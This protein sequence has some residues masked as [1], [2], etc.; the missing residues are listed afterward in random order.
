[1][2]ALDPLRLPLRG[3]QV[4]EASAG[5]GKTWTLAALYLR[6]VI[7]HGRP[8][9]TG[10]SPRQILVMTFTEAATAELRE[11]IRQRLHDAAVWFE[12]KLA[13]KPVDT[14]SFMDK[15]SADIPAQEWPQCVRR[16]LLAA[17]AMDEAA[18][19]T[20]HGWS[21]RMLSSF[22]LFS[23]DVFEQTHLDNPNEL[24]QQ[25]VRDHWRRWFYPLPQNL[26]QTLLTQLGDNPDTLLAELR[27]QWKTWDLLPPAAGN[28]A[29]ETPAT[30]PPLD[31]LTVFNDWQTKYQALEAEARQSWQADL[32]DRLREAR[33]AGLIKAAGIS[34]P[35][36]YKWVDELQDWAV[37]GKEIRPVTLKRFA[38]DKL[39]K[40]G[41]AAA[42]DFALFKQ[43]PRMVEFSEHPPA[44]KTLLIAHAAHAVRAAY[45]QA[46]LNQSV[47]DF[48]DLLQRL[49]Q[50]LH[51]DQGELAAAIRQQY[52]VAMVDEFQ[53][54]DP[55]QYESLDRIYQ[56]D[57]VDDSNVLVMIGDPKQAIYSF[58]GADLSTYLRAREYALAL[59]P[60]ACHT[61]DT[62]YR[63][64][65]A[66]VT[67]V[68]RVFGGID[69][70]FTSD[71]HSI[72]FTPVKSASDAL[73]LS[74]AS[75]QVQAPLT[76]WHLP[77]PPGITEKKYWPARDHVQTMAAGFASQM[78]VLLKQHPE[79]HPGQMAVLVRSHAHA[80]A[81]QS[82][83]TNVGLPSVF[84]SD[85]ANVYQ[86][87]EALDL[88][89]V[90]RAISMPRQTRWL[91]SAMAGSLWG[92]STEELTHAMHNPDLSDA[93]A[94]SCQQWLQQWQQHGVLPMLYHW[95]HSQGIAQRL[96]AQPRGDRRL[97]NLLHLGELLQTAAAGLQGPQALL[98]FLAQQMQ[99]AEDNPE[100]QKMR[101]ETDAH[102]VQVITF[103][104]SK[105]L[106]Y[107][108]VFVPF[109]GSFNTEVRR[110]DD[111]EETDITESSVDED[112]R[113]LYVALTRAKRGMWLGVAATSNGLSGDGATLKLSAVSAL[114]KRKNH[115]DL[116]SRLQAQYEGVP[117]IAVAELPAPQQLVYAPRSAQTEA[118]TPL[119]A[120]REGYA[121]WWTA[122]FSSLTRGLEAGSQTEEG[123]TDAGIDAARHSDSGAT[124]DA[125]D[126]VGEHAQGSYQQ[127]PK[128]AR[129][130]TLL[131]DLLDW[132]AQQGWPLANSNTSA[133]LQTAWQQWLQR[134]TRGLNLSESDQTVLSDWLTRLLR[135][136]L[137]LDSVMPGVPPLV[138]Q[139]L[140]PATQW[141][142][143]EFNFSATGVSSAWLDTHI[144]AHVLPGQARP[145]LQSRELQGMLTG[146]MDLVC[147]H[148]GRYWVLDYKS[149]WLTAYD[150]A[151]LNAAV[152][153]KRYEV[154]YVLYLLALHRLLKS[155]L[156][157]YDYDTHIGGAVYVFLRG[158]DSDGAGVHAVKPPRE[159]VL[160]LDA[161]FAGGAT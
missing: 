106:E 128:G 152:L 11:R 40:A 79:L 160:Q 59:D 120:K 82:A 74:D 84:L 135:S 52:P 58:R 130:G 116:L 13:D 159:L 60:Q 145:A 98:H 118:Q 81:M 124:G 32:P 31:I 95:I 71:K 102:C 104:K 4:I 133:S 20:L 148:A 93:L 23:R 72:E 76:F 25:L 54:T 139:Q 87:P 142:E 125:G 16:L 68:N 63:S 18:I 64:A 103:H 136:P 140:A 137:P 10:L 65:P 119:T 62:N 24:L 154:Q 83:L 122:S 109:L 134:K 26:Q 144:Q 15:L 138:L 141:P 6:S 96:L 105:G 28:V 113:L 69:K 9:N 19:Y 2:N 34:T 12:Q 126:S 37:H 44:C 57:R 88:W 108:L 36:F 56:A 5:T 90:L 17:H 7:G 101:L 55:W 157:G 99:A 94:E 155:R 114:L 143:M 30:A 92:W 21:R 73:P 35:N 112:M 153:D 42:K 39:V 22:A 91:R 61:L 38:Q 70:P 50:A 8:D 149:N 86:S 111:E 127:F 1:M 53:D 75:G 66:L 156:P 14:D 77:L 43:I 80:H 146:F 147:E 115:D 3:R 47:F 78:V 27:K 151:A 150:S 51:A 123:S 107:P 48:N 121:R 132:Q 67:A 100:E 110:K 33:E 131:H 46:K 45:Q 161:A 117:E 85:H 158:I 129:Y 89:R 97:T 49:H 29:V 41:W